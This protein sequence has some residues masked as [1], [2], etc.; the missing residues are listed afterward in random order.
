LDQIDA[1]SMQYALDLV[2]PQSA[3]IGVHIST[4]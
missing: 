4:F 3:L 1:P 2:C